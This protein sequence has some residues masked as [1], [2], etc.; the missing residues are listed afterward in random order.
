MNIMRRPPPRRLRLAAIN[1]VVCFAAMLVAAP[2]IAAS[3]Q[4]PDGT[5]P[6]CRSATVAVARRANPPLN[7]REWIVVPFGNV[8]KAPDLEWLRDASVNL[9]S[10][11][12]SRWTDISVVDDKRVT[13]LI[14]ELPATRTAQPLSLND[15][16]ALARRAG[17]GRLVMGDFFKLGKGARLVAN[18]FNVR[19]GSR[20]RSITQQTSEQDSL[21]TAFGPLARGVLAVPPPGD[22][23]LGA[24]G[25]TNVDAYQEYLLGVNL[26][27]RFE[28]TD[29]KQ[30]L[31]KALAF[32]STF[33]LAHYKLSVAIHWG[34][35]RGDTTE[36]AHALA[37]WRLGGSLPPRERALISGRVA[38]TGGDYMR[39]CATLGAL[40]AKDSSDVEALYGVGECQYHAGLS[41]PVP[42][43]SLYGRFLGSWN[44][45]IAAFHRVLQ[46]DPTYHPA[47]GHILDA[48]SA[49]SVVVCAD[50]S[51]PI[52]G[53][54]PRSWQATVLRDGDS[55]L[56]RPTQARG[57]TPERL[58]TLQ[59]QNSSRSSMLNLLAS[60]QI[61]Q[62]WVEAGPT[63]SRARLSLA[64]VDLL[65]G[66]VA[67]ADSELRAIRNP[68]DRF[69]RMRALQFRV[70]VAIQLGRAS[71]GRATLDSLR[72]EMPD[73]VA[74]DRDLGA[75]YAAFGQFQP[76]RSA[77]DR[78]AAT[79]KWSEERR[80]YWQHVPRVLL[81]IPRA[82]LAADERRYWES[83]STDTLCTGGQSGCRTTLLLQTQGFAPRVPRSWWPHN[84]QLPP[85]FRFRLGY[86]IPKGDTTALHFFQRS[87]DSVSHAR[88]ASG[89]DEQG[90]S[91]VV[92]EV[93]LVAGDSLR[94][95]RSARFAVDSVM[96]ILSR[97]GTNAGPGDG[98][99]SILLVPRMMLLRADLA[100]ALGFPDE[101]RTWY[102]RM[103][104]LWA[105]ADPE[106]QPTVA[107]IR[108]AF[109]ALGGS[110]R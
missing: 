45:A 21:L 9:L 55:L 98:D 24:T 99:W 43:D 56:I 6:P 86:V 87:M 54:D 42:V 18:V 88:V 50:P 15:G 36:R 82:G 83:A 29:A 5:P 70:Q 28:L 10:L 46:L 81:G 62:E 27:N 2:S 108:A 97:L 93:H 79:G 35:T 22:A 7:E 58:A 11:D 67:Q 109:T 52:C 39:A 12:L 77:I 34:D 105:E 100:A 69:T 14:R 47:F 103:L 41:A 76:L 85:G 51:A 66:N 90:L 60:R 13:D 26:L 106:L 64:N 92:T 1:R 23:K 19:D 61:A 38:S 65:L 74:R 101:A 17:A 107:R 16:L 4:C 73:P 57:L 78:M 84:E 49:G 3:A 25:T 44:T 89:G 53:N 40:A 32:D 37:A 48:L 59:R 31:L 68:A 95:L 30:H 96:P 63:E 20:I 91:V 71:E 8:S 72:R 33:A 75:Y 102:T 94:A 104:D 110:R 80:V